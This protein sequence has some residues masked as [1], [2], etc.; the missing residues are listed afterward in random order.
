MQRSRKVAVSLIATIALMGTAL[1]VAAAPASAGGDT[2]DGKVTLC[3][4]T[5]SATN[6]YVEI[7]VDIHAAGAS[8]GLPKGGHD[9]H[10]EPVVPT[11]FDNA[12]E[13]K[14]ADTKWGDVIPAY[15]FEGFDYPGLNLSPDGEALLDNGCQLRGTPDDRVVYRLIRRMPLGIEKVTL[16]AGL[17]PSITCDT[18]TNEYVVT[19]S[20]DTEVRIDVGVSKQGSRLRVRSEGVV[21][22]NVTA[23]EVC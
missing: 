10:D 20:D 14:A 13:L 19:F 16:T 12:A 9:G 5:F 21:L 2:I 1:V 4:A 3:H 22:A 17:T 11:D 8:Q 6:P 15:S 7:T 18:N 23:S